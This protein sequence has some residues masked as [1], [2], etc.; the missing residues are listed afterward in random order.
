[1]DAVIALDRLTRRYGE[2]VAVDELSLRVEPG[3]VYALVGLNGAGKTTAIRMLLGMLRPSG[4]SVRLFGERPHPNAAGIWR[5]VG[6][7]V[8][9]P[10]AYPELTVRQN[11]DVFRRLRHLRDAR[12]VDEAIARLGL[13][14][15]ADLRADR[16]SL[17][18]RQRLG[19]A[20][21][22]L[23][24]PSL[25]I[26]DEPA[27]GLDPQGIRWLRDLLRSLASEGRTILVSS[28]V[29][30]EV[31]QTVDD[32]VIVH[33]GRFVAHA[34]VAEVVAGAGA[35]RVRSPQ[36]ARLRELLAREGLEATVSG[37]DTLLVTGTTTDR[38]GELAA[39]GGVVLHELSSDR[40]TLEEAFLALTS[41]E[42]AA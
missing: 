8:E 32:V 22:L 1:M 17:G 41:G 10:R 6:Y 39:A 11:L 3:E 14:E 37:R 15:Y 31:A 36:A 27:N 42:Q 29:L 38:V 40:G 18:N 25:L 28:H 7:M 35:V 16:L 19:L 20:R 21:A 9:V 24:E 33:R 5:R 34:P 4:G 2:R 23:H 12:V 13:R 26:L 30:A